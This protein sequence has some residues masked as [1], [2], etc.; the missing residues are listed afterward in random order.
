MAL[1]QSLANPS[2]IILFCGVQNVLALIWPASVSATLT[3]GIVSI[4]VILARWYPN[5]IC[6]AT[7]G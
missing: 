7:P 3:I 2:L 4:C 5:R 1:I 6:L